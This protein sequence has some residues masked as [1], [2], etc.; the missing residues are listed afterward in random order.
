MQLSWRPALL[1][2]ALLLVVPVPHVPAQAVA[3]GA[4]LPAVVA[5]A[6]AGTSTGPAAASSTAPP[7][8]DTV[9]VEKRTGRLRGARGAG[10]KRCG[11]GTRKV[12]LRVTSP[13]KVCRAADRS[14][15]LVGRGRARTAAA[16]TA[17]PL[18]GTVEKVPGATRVFVCARGTR[19]LQGTTAARGCRGPR[20]LVRFRN[21]R[22]I[23]LTLSATTVADRSPAGTVVGTLAATERN[24][25]D[26]L[27]W[28]L[29]S[30]AGDSDNARFTVQGD[31]LVV[32]G[33]VD[34]RTH[35]TL[36]VRVEASDLGGKVNAR[37]FTLQVTGINQVPTAVHLSGDTV[38]EQQ[39]AGTLVGRFR[40]TDPDP[41]DSFRYSITPV[42]GL[43]V[44]GDELRTSRPLGHRESPL[45]FTV[46]STDRAGAQTQA[47]FVVTVRDVANDPDS[48]T[49]DG[50]DSVEVAEFTPAGPIG[51]LA[52]TDDE[53]TTGFT[54]DLVGGPGDDDNALFEV[55]GDT[56]RTLAPLAQKQARTRSV[57]VRVTDPDGGTLALA[58]T[59]RVTRTPAAPTALNLIGNGVAENAPI[60][61]EVGILT[62]EDANADETFT[63]TLPDGESDN[64]DFR[65]AG[66]RLVTARSF[67][68]E[69]VQSR[70]VTVTVTDRDGRSLT[71][72][73]TVR[74]AD[75]NE[76]PTGLTLTGATVAEGQ[77]G[78]TVGQLSAT[79]P[80]QRP[81]TFS[82][83]PDADDNAQFTVVDGELRTAVPLRFG[84][85]ATRRVLVRVSDGVN[86]DTEQFVVTVLKNK[87][88]PTLGG[89]TPGTV[90]EN[91]PAG[92]VVGTLESTD[93]N[94]DPLTHELVP[95]TGAT[96]NASF[97]VVGDQVRTTRAFDHETEPTLSIRVRVTDTD[98]LSDEAVLAVR[99]TDAPEAP[100][101]LTLSATTTVA[102]VPDAV[103]GTFTTT[104]PDV[105]DTFTYGLTDGAG[106]NDNDDFQVVGDQ[107]R[108]RGALSFAAG[109]T[110]SVRVTTTDRAQLTHT[111]VFTITVDDP[112]TAPTGVTLTPDAVAENSPFSTV[113]GQ[114]QAAD[115]NATDVHSYTLVAGN[116]AA[117]NHRFVVVGPELRVVGSLDHETLPLAHVRVRATDQTQRWVEEE[118][119]VT[120]TDVNE[121]PVPGPTTLTVAENQPAGTL[122]GQL[123]AVDPEQEPL[124]WSTTSTDFTVSATGEVRSRRP[125]DFETLP[126]PDLVASVTDGVLPVTV[127]VPVTVTDVNEAP[128]A[129][130]LSNTT[131]PENAPVGTVVGT[132]SATDPDAG[133]VLTFASQTSGF[134][135]VDDQLRT[136][137][138]FDHE[139]TPSVTVTVSVSDTRL[140]AST[141]VAVR[142]LDVDEAPVVGNDTYQGLVGN[143]AARLGGPAAFPEVPLAGA[144]LLANDADPEGAEVRVVPG[145]VTTTEGGSVTLNATGGFSYRPRAGLKNATDTFTYQ[146][147]DGSLT[148]SGTASLVLGARAVWYVDPSVAGPGTGTSADPLATLPGTLGVGGDEIF[149]RNGSVSI[150]SF[151]FQTGQQLYGAAEGLTIGDT[152]LVPP[153]GSSTIHVT[154]TGLA[155]AGG[156]SIRSLDLTGTGAAT[157][158]LHATDVDAFSVAS[159]V[160]VTAG[161][162]TA[163]DVSGGTG[164]ITMTA[165]VLAG[166]RAPAVRIASRTGTT[167]LA[168]ISSGPG[169]T[170]GLVLAS[171][172]TVELSAQLAMRTGPHPALDSARTD[173]RDTSATHH[174]LVSTTGV[175][176][177]LT[178][179]SLA[180]DLRLA[181]VVSDGAVS[182]IR[183]VGTGGTGRVVLDSTPALRSLVANSTDVGILVERSRGP[184]LDQVVVRDGR[185]QGV[186]FADLVDANAQVTGA[187]IRNNLG[188]GVLVSGAVAGSRTALSVTDSVFGANTGDHVQVAASGTS[189]GTVTIARNTFTGG[190]PSG[191]QG[192][193]VAAGGSFTGDLRFSVTDNTL[194]GS[195]GNAVAVAAATT[196]PGGILQGRVVNNTIGSTTQRCST[197]ANG[198]E[199]AHDQGQGVVRVA[200]TD[201]TIRN[202]EQR[203]ISLLT[204]DGASS[205]EATVTGNQVSGL[206]SETSGYGFEGTFGLVPG[207]TQNS[208][209][210]LRENTFVGAGTLAGARVRVRY[211]TLGAP[212]YLGGATDA[213]GFST[214]LSGRNDPSTVDVTSLPGATFAQR[215]CTG[216]AS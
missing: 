3:D 22:P 4:V 9:C 118:L 10:P 88:A 176:V 1:L 85:G 158:V 139:A 54:Y 120:V 172:G 99:V 126:H 209:L 57:R 111:R 39:P 147:S 207:D 11:S 142:V 189:S 155:L 55:V 59:V 64:A 198:I 71:R 154:G 48:L 200:V 202:C 31:R 146:V 184:V 130:V 195:P 79:D 18:R 161:P 110:R 210:D 90:T 42:D 56:L 182:G 24:T 194:T 101:G 8:I 35:P 213:A 62:A 61:T 2:S 19:L 23:A 116:G 76:A 117:D 36:R 109:S 134:T 12:V 66:D 201:N 149:V 135:V 112:P 93:P 199:V 180:T 137:R 192:V 174:T 125:F 102:G 188:D 68:F 170:G 177:R 105:G 13:R 41:Q 44:T 83:V 75:I 20:Q 152:L 28:R 72:T 123:T 106:A 92:T 157:T 214:Y 80:E 30:G 98:N 204:G 81:L 26:R 159:S 107:L 203:G 165:P 29:V 196:M 84:D 91:L 171:A 131:V 86:S 94:G 121:A 156:V 58:F 32:A 78:V 187:E 46:T 5:T 96:H 129:P 74:V 73:L 216:P 25:G 115:P 82:L 108:T 51:T 211:G 15:Y 14:L 136:T 133:A 138:V 37:S 119:V 114:L 63:Y 77:A 104:D 163:L 27:T 103:V 144:L 197:G 178:D 206:T 122:V 95:G 175:P 45:R 148:A 21:A 87:Q 150:P 43:V 65:V 169:T 52:A 191:A 168:G 205:L 100:T 132:L 160:R 6:S 162:A 145:T 215:T 113:V 16:C 49:L 140:A 97:S 50:G 186:V 89:L 47:S 34:G 193:V 167:T 179:G 173:L 33:T 128:S 127:T 166:S 151:T 53:S 124:R 7:V 153:G 164:R 190:A 17:A 60:G 143:T 181:Q 183:V 70:Q 212:Q 38:D 185:K 69:T 141:V 208:C 40:T 67:D